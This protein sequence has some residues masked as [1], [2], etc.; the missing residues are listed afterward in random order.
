MI[1][2]SSILSADFTN[3]RDQVLSA[4]R[5][6]VDWIHVDVMDGHFVPNIT[7][8]AFMVET[9]KRITN[10][11]IDAHLM[12]EQPERHIKA[13][14]DAGAA[15]VSVHIED[16]PNIHRTLHSIRLAG[17]RPGIVLNPGT[18]A[19]AVE[20][21]LPFVDYVLVM[22]VDPGFSGGEF[23]PEMA[24]KVAGIRQMLDRIHSNALIEV[25][26]GITAETLP[27]MQRA[28]ADVFVAATAIF[29]FPDGIESGVRALRGVGIK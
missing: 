27:L 11:P 28:G 6:G 9:V 7:M 17:A 5:A 10:L 22:T 1:L 18:P 2:S 26:G 13:F 14:I 12:V 16:N 3:L 4:E 24:G 29:K 19:S 21:V 20:A 8:G 15:Y 25:D 23:V